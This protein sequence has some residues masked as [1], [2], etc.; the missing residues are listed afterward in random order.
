[1]LTDMSQ[2]PS[3]EMRSKAQAML[4]NI[5]AS[6]AKMEATRVDLD[7]LMRTNAANHAAALRKIA[8]LKAA[9]DAA[10]RRR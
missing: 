9:K 1:M 8:E 7:A 5:E 3:P 6:I 4:E 2:L 10:L